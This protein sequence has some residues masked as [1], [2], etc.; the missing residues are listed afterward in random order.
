MNKVIRKLF[1]SNTLY[2]VIFKKCLSFF[3]LKS[4]HMVKSVCLGMFRPFKN[5]QI[6]KGNVKCI[7][8][9][10][11]RVDNWPLF[12]VQKIFFLLTF[13]GHVS[14]ILAWTKCRLVTKHVL[15]I[16]HFLYAFFLLFHLNFIYAKKLSCP[17]PIKDYLLLIHTFMCM[18]IF[19]RIIILS[20]QSHQI[21][22]L[23]TGLGMAWN[24]DGLYCICLQ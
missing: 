20:F 21:R 18:L 9:Y 4:V 10:I 5:V 7:F 17:M 2:S 13:F 12:N 16:T 6:F 14:T 3:K 19:L 22:I 24:P 23:S 8:F 1:I 11:K 15:T